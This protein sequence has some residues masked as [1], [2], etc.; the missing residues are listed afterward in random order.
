MAQA[1]L[2]ALELA[3][4]DLLLPYKVDL[5]LLEHIDNPALR[6]HIARVGRIFWER[7]ESPSC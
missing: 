4:D 1:D 3:I 2:L 7:N 6:E 5:S